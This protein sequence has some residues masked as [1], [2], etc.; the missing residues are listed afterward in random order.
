MQKI[1]GNLSLEISA[2]GLV[3]QAFRSTSL[4]ADSLS[5]LRFDPLEMAGK[6]PMHGCSQGCSNVCNSKNYS[7]CC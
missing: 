2:M 1:A 4:K 3:G 5:A 7:R 6:S